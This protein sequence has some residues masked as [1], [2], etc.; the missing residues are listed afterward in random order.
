[1]IDLKTANHTGRELE[2]MLAGTKPLSEFCGEIGELP[3]EEIIPE[4]KFSPFVESGQFVRGQTTVDAAFHP[5]W[6]RNVQITYVLFALKSEAWRIVEMID[7][8]HSVMRTGWNEQ[9]ERRSSYLLGYTQEEIDAWCRA[10]Y[11][12]E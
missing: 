6:N 5:A 12:P 4:F 11:V 1:M 10:I 3:D 2:L 7:L 8:Q 9:I